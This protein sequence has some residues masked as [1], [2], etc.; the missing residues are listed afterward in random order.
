MPKSNTAV[1][2]WPLI[3]KLLFCFFF[4]FFLLYIFLN[5]N[6]IIPYSY[7]LHKLYSGPCNALIGWLA[8]DVFQLVSPAT[9]FYNGTIDTVF[10]YVTLLFIFFA[11][12]CGA[13]VW[14]VIDK[15]KPG[16]PKL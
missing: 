12:F 9:R 16:Y 5:P 6:D 10:G 4:I 13:V 15:K 8:K 7:Y 3:K 14:V 2:E 1:K 11:A